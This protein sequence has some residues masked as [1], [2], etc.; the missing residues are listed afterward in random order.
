MSPNY[1]HVAALGSSFAAG[2][3]IPPIVDRFALRSGRNYAHVLAD[4]LGER[5]TDLT[6]SGATTT[7]ILER[8]QRVL[9][10]NPASARGC[11]PRRRPRDDYR[12]R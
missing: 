8:P 7:N 12:R 2:P 11:A 4:R 5:L 3:G 1:R 9:I 6:V 10:R